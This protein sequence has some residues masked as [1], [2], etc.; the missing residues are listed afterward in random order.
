MH[1]PKLPQLLV[2]AALALLSSPSVSADHAS[3]HTPNHT[4]EDAATAQSVSFPAADGIQITADLYQATS[5]QPKDTAIV[6]FHQARSSR[7][8]YG[9]IAPRLA[10]LGY[11]VLAVDQRS[12]GSNSGVR[13]QTH[14]AAQDAGKSTG[15]L[16][17]R[18]DLVAAVDY[19]K[20]TLKP[21]RV[22]VWGSSYSASLVLAL[23]GEQPD[24]VD[25]ALAFSP[26]E[27]FRGEWSVADAAKGIRVPTFITSAKGEWGNWS[28][29]RAAIPSG[30]LTAFRP[31]G[32]GRHGSSTLTPV[33]SVAAKEYWQA[34]EGFLAAHF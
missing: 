21:A 4:H 22:V 9:K 34:V 25:G 11:P 24:W 16:A 31:K 27:Y 2:I 8:E 17:A 10:V 23:A 6:V 33:S 13:N 3:N 30:D 15:F 1:L 7:G 28:G 19:A 26:G 12:G 29:I 14:A 5:A 20:S 32:P 18:Q